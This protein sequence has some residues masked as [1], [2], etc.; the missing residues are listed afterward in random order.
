[1]SMLIQP[2]TAYTHSTHTFLHMVNVKVAK[3]NMFSNLIK[4]YSILRHM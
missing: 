3:M 4:R 1:M 2:S